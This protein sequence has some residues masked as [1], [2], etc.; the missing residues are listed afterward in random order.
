MTGAERRERRARRRRL[1][2]ISHLL[3][4]GGT[5]VGATL[6]LSALLIGAQGSPKAD[7]PVPPALINDSTDGMTALRRELAEAM[8]RLTLAESKLNRANAIAANAQ[9]FKISIPLATA[10]YD[11]AVTEDID[12]MVGF[13]LVRIESGFKETATSYKDAIGYTQLRLATARIYRPEVT[14]SD[15]HDRDLNLGIGFRYLRDLIR[16]FGGNVAWALLAYNQGPT[17][18]DSVLSE[19]GDPDNGY[20]EAVMTGRRI[21]PPVTDS[22]GRTDSTGKTY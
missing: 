16:R 15:L 6:V 13:Q 11:I 3:V 20:A 18:V 14:Q 4:R 7:P 21:R 22:A 2:Q 19:G 17:M 12:P 1:I 9:R 8:A 10:I 5:L